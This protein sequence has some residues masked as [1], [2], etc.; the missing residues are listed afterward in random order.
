MPYMAER[1]KRKEE[2]HIIPKGPKHRQPKHPAQPRL[3]KS[4]ITHLMLMGRMRTHLPMPR[5]MYLLQSKP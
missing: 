5:K 3:K 2:R 4:K 1:Y